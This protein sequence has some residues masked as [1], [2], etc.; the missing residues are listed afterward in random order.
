MFQSLL[1]KLPDLDFSGKGAIFETFRKLHPILKEQHFLNPK[2]EED[3]PYEST[4]IT[5]LVANAHGIFGVYSMREVFEY[6]RFWA[7]GTGREFALGAMHTQ[8]GR[9]RSAAAIAKVGIDAG[10]TFDKNSGLPMSLYTVPLGADK[11][12]PSVDPKPPFSDALARFVFERSAVRGALVSLDDACRDILACH[13][14]PPALKRVLAELLAAAALL[15]STLKFKGALI[16]QLQGDGPVRLLVVECDATLS[17]RATAQWKDTADALPV[18]AS[19]VDLAGGP[20]HGRLAI[21]LDPKDGGPIYQGIVALEAASIATL[22]EHYLVT[23]EQIDSRMTLAAEGTRVRGLLL[24]RLPGATAADDATWSHAAARIDSMSSAALLG[25]VGAEDFLRANFPD[26]DVRLF[27]ARTARFAC[28][29]SA[30]R[31]ANALRLLGRAEVE[32]I[33]TEQGMI[34]VTCEFCNRSYTFVAEE[35]RALF[36]SDHGARSAPAAVPP[37]GIRH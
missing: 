30:E 16:V 27:A 15:A 9:L 18:D 3:D 31:V 6:T 13:P 36:P 33:L 20:D 2:E 35:A 17:L 29:C 14:Y 1:A 7:A 5:A 26:D 11:G 37:D 21:T 25:S 22:I 32:S 12:G 8:Y 4:Q 28:S 23:S 34:G 10:T 19:L 24:Q